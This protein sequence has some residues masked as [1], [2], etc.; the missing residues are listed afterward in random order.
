MRFVQG[1]CGQAQQSP[2]VLLARVVLAI[3]ERMN[4]STEPNQTGAPSEP[5]PPAADRLAA[6]V[7]SSDDAI[8]GKD[9][10]GTI[11][12]WNRG[13]EKVFGYTAE[14]MLGTSILRL[15]PADRHAEEPHIL[16]MIRRGQSVTHFE[17]QRL[18]K[19]GRRIDVSVTASPIR[20]LTGEIT[21]VSKVARDISAQR[22]A[23]EVL[24]LFR[25][26]VDQSSDTFEVI[27]PETSR[28][29]DVN[30]NGPRELGCSRAEYL[31]L[32]VVD[33]DPTIREADWPNLVAA[34]RA[35]GPVTGEG[36]HRR[37]DGTTFPVEYSAKWVRLDRD[38]IVT[39]VRDITPRKQAEAELHLQ[40]LHAQS[41]LRLSRKLERV[42]SLTDILRAAR[43]EVEGTL[44]FKLV[45]LYL[46]SEDRKF[47]RFV[48]ADEGATP[49]NQP[50][51][52]KLLLIAGDPM[53]EEIATGQDLV[54][55]ED[56]RTDPRTNKTIVAR[57]GNRTLVN[58]PVFLAGRRLGAIGTGTF[59]DEGVRPLSSSD[60]EFLTALA[61]HAAAVIDRVAAA[62]EQVKTE[63]ALRQS[64]A[65]FAKAFHSNPAA[66]CITTIRDGRFIEVNERYCKIL[67]HA[68][69]ELIGQS[70]VRLALWADPVTR[71]AMVEELQAHGYI[72]DHE[73][74]FRR[75]N[76]DLVQVQISMELI[77]FPGEP[78][79]VI[80]SMFTDITERKRTEAALRA[81]EER[82][83]RV[84]DNARVGLVMINRE[85]RYTFANGTYAEILSLPSADLVGQRVA[86]VLAPLYEAQ[87]RPRLDQA[88]AGERVAYE[89]NQRTTAEVRHYAVRYEPTRVDGEI[90]LIVVVITDITERK[91]LEEQL[92]QAQKMEA[93]GQLAGGIAHDFNNLLAAIIGN[94]DLARLITGDGH[95]SQEH[96]DA[97]LSAS[98]RAT[99]LVRQILAFS[100]Q[101]SQQRQPL[102]LHFVV[103]EALKLLR[104]TVPADIE[105]RASLAP[106][107]TVLA[108]PSEIHQITMNL[109]TNAWHA[110]K[111]RAGTITVELAETDLDESHARQHPDLRPGRYVRLT[112]ADTGCGMDAA[113]QERMF[114]PFFTTK[115]VGEG[116][117]L[118][119]SVVHG[120]VKSHDGGILVA[121]QP[122]AGT[123]FHLYFPV[124]AGEII[125]APGA[126]LPIPHGQNE[127]V[128]LVDDEAA[129][130]AMGKAALERLGYRVV[131]H[132]SPAA[133]LAEFQSRPA[134]FD[135]VITDYNMPGMNGAEFG[136]QVLATRPGQ[137]MILTS[138][139][140]VRMNR[141]SSLALGF[142]EL[143]PKPYD[144]RGLGEAVQ[145]VLAADGKTR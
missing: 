105:F 137:R 64:E 36:F 13:A 134:E 65:R 28:F 59:G 72:R 71:A 84:T 75:K 11:T 2:A 111:G 7:E 81:S 29:L 145:R 51:D 38:Y 139:F 21:G 85:R 60:R 62:A 103:K 26:L 108:D 16:G 56:A 117:G 114:E 94:A 135:L 9:L 10:N 1:N 15:I 98:H 95:E 96:L 138:G 35:N 55:V 25:T 112:V 83:R 68:R 97:I 22:R 14:E 32:R 142:G 53:L 70:S 90:T 102:Q 5:V 100:R 91:Q 93:I 88:F 3:R 41:L 45:W 86:D 33:I 116:T 104:A 122:G 120:I 40:Q 123:T 67:D 78:E 144:L 101:Q 23:E 133:A 12:S 106:T 113:T 73:A 18:T 57:L 8:L 4:P 126:P 6:I 109:C 87:I 77:E 44:G 76:G 136:A 24:K 141:E 115:P 127:L 19:D 80:V 54:V 58:V 31:A 37:K 43:E 30:E 61:S 74:H 82:L 92:R 20:S 66:M 128:L 34:M 48:T 143:L 27:D 89:L 132:T 125:A 46:I 52:G 47:L 79:P 121:S 17:T 124:F 119:L 107:P 49:R 131:R 50:D 140:S 99:D 42:E 129:L 63:A 39:T 69:D 110:M 118:G 130:A